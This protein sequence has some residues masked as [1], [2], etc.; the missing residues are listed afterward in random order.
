MR[1]AVLGARMSAPPP[2]KIDPPSPSG[3]DA[4]RPVRTLGTPRRR[5]G[6]APGD[7]SPGRE[8]WASS[9]DAPTEGRRLSRPVAVRTD[10][11]GAGPTPER[12]S[13]PHS[14]SGVGAASAGPS[15]PGPQGRM[16]HRRPRRGALDRASDRPRP[17][18]WEPPRSVGTVGDRRDIA[19]GAGTDSGGDAGRRSGDGDAR[20]L[21]QQVVWAEEYARAGAPGRLGH[22][23]ENLL[24]PTLLVH[25]DSAQRARFL[26]PI[27]RGEELW[28]QGYSEPDA[29]SDLAGLLD[30]RRPRPGRGHL[31]HHRAEDLD[32]PRP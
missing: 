11:S 22:I 25:G 19:P 13:A 12:R 5:R 15:P 28:C 26:P 30:P 10:G 8:P 16:P 2:E 20:T 1:G 18:A 9:S 3:P 7:G 23:G 24:A 21:T 4:R 17:P 14:A 32:L 6:R 31:S 29:G 27:A